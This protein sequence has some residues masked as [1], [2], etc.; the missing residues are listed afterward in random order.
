[1]LNFL[2][3][4]KIENHFK[5]YFYLPKKINE[6]ENNKA[7]NFVESVPEYELPYLF[8]HC[9]C[10]IVSLNKKLI[11][12]NIPGKFVS[13]IQFGL[14]ILSF[15]NKQSKLANLINEYRCGIVIDYEDDLNLNLTKI[16]SFVKKLNQK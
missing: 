8:K 16:N 15:C 1:M 10:G 2:K 9:N 14:P 5:F 6:L 11:T 3:K 13:Y 12:N 4:I 7:F